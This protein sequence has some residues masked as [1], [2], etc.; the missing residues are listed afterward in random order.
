MR[1][2]DSKTVKYAYYAV[3][4]RDKPEN[5]RWLTVFAVLDHMT[6]SLPKGK[7]GIMD[8]LHYVFKPLTKAQFDTHIAFESLE[9]KD[10]DDFSI[11]D[12]EFVDEFIDRVGNTDV[13]DKQK[14]S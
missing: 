4:E 3:A 9:I 11:A 10:S 1:W 5:F 6:C 8:T 7:E 14:Q 13:L 2:D 12:V